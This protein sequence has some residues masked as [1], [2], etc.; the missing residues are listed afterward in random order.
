MITLNKVY[1]YCAYDSEACIL[2]LNKRKILVEFIKIAQVS[3]VPLSYAFN[4][5]G[6]IKV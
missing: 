3:N 4:R 2:L 1:E 5:A 6:G